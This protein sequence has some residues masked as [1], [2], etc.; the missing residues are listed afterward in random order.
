METDWSGKYRGKN[1]LETFK[2]PNK[3]LLWIINHIAT[4]GGI[5]RPIHGPNGVS[6]GYYGKKYK[7]FTFPSKFNANTKP[8]EIQTKV[9]F[10][11]ANPINIP[12]GQEPPTNNKFP[13]HN[14][15]KSY[16]YNKNSTQEKWI[17]VRSIPAQDKWFKATDQLMGTDKYTKSSGE[18]SNSYDINSVSEFKFES[19]DKTHFLIASKEAVIGSKPYANDPRNIKSSSIN[20]KSY[21]AKWYRRIANKEDPWISIKDHSFSNTIIYGGNSSKLYTNIPKK[22]WWSKS[23]Y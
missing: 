3:S 15:W 13:K 10:Y 16:K 5:N 23:I 1:F 11:F 14:I 17:L 21:K 22:S 20:N 7:Y 19:G 12:D 2:Y 9:R 18:F 4:N 6:P 8:S